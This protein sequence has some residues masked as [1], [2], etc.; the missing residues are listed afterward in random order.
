MN[1]L[2]K[3]RKNFDFSLY[4]WEILSITGVV[5]CLLTYLFFTQMDLSSL[6]EL[7]DEA[8]S[9]A[10]HHL[11]YY[12]NE[13]ASH[14][15]ES[16]S[17]LT[18]KAVGLARLLDDKQNL[19]SDDFSEYTRNQHISGLLVIDENFQPVYQFD[20][21]GLT[22]GDWNTEILSFPVSDI[23]HFP[24]KHYMG[25][26][27]KNGTSYDFAAIARLD[28]P[29]I[30]LVYKRT[31]QKN[32]ELQASALGKLFSNYTLQRGGEILLLEDLSNISGMP[33]TKDTITYSTLDSH[34]FHESE[35]G[36]SEI[37]LHEG[38]EISSLNEKDEDVNERN[39]GNAN[40]ADS[41]DDAEE[42]FTFSCDF[43]YRYHGFLKCQMKGKTWY[44]DAIR[45]NGYT[46]CIFFPS[47]QIFYQR[48]IAM[49]FVISLYIIFMLLMILL[50]KDLDAKNMEQLD[51]QYRIIEAIG[52]I[53]ETILIVDLKTNIL[54]PIT[55]PDYLFENIPAGSSAD[56]IFD[57]WINKY[58]A[59]DYEQKYREFMDF[60]TVQERIGSNTH[61]ELKY[62]RKD[63]VWCQ[64]IIIPKRYDKSHKIAS[65]LLVTRNIS[66]EMQHELAV[67]QQ[68][69]EAADEA[70][71]AN[72][73]K[74]DFLRRMSHD[75][76]T[77]INGIRGM[78]EIADHFP[79]DFEKQSECRKKIFQASDF[80]LDLVNSVLDMNKLE[81]G[82]LILEE[83]PF[84]L[85]DIS[86]DVSTIIR[87][88]A[89]EH[90]LILKTKNHFV[91]HHHLIGSPLY[92][93]QILLNLAG[94][95]VKYNRPGGSITI[96]CQESSSD[97]T[98]ATFVFIIED[99]GLGMSEE[100][101][102]H[103]FE[104]FSQENIAGRS[105]YTGTGLGL[106]ITK[107]LIEKMGGT[108]HFSSRQ[109]VGTKFIVTI[110]FK[111]DKDHESSEEIQSANMDCD[112]NGVHVLLVEDNDLNREIV[113]F[114]LESEGIVVTS[115]INGQQA[116]D[117]FKESKPGSFHFILMDVMMPVMDGIEA[118]RRIRALDRPDA[119]SIPIFAM[120]ANAFADDIR[121]C[122]EAGMNEHLAKPLD[123]KQL[124]KLMHRY[125]CSQK[126]PEPSGAKKNI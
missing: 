29:G 34:D 114:L 118:T 26:T 51:R 68:L 107:E 42:N 10:S 2:K 77:P 116:L 110:P 31:T 15:T 80:L 104:P 56:E 94:N 41:E 5:L 4:I 97:E 63:G 45:V 1:R 60:S 27:E 38:K 101:Q 85:N 100:F 19:S 90:G 43:G 17:A 98:T 37:I 12:M 36:K 62:L 71:R 115:T 84:F 46:I 39:D 121:Q 122:R 93:R 89:L 35:S 78:I 120:T 124:F 44:G 64:V 76:R 49:F 20:Q 125:F 22:A 66:E 88:Q 67:N 73:A 57:C 59:P 105:S 74:T 106:S 52:N 111:I 23:L 117:T 13:S 81:S 92:L 32:D 53:Y 61:I 55:A 99:T 8:L 75:I 65:I 7:S 6:K 58:I 112:L 95:A 25:H 18:D 40:D 82:E 9:S 3:I 47:S 108:I 70:K 96:S 86:H 91:Q 123:S 48:S 54:E 87:P 16:L 24:Q 103:L 102:K 109:N 126:T 21:N 11:S 79:D 50:R 69:R 28:A 72:A 30:I 113:E 119:G 33:S 83:V 14:R